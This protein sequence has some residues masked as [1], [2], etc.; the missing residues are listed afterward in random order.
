MSAAET[1]LLEPRPLFNP[2]HN[3]APFRL[4]PPA[5]PALSPPPAG[6]SCRAS[7]NRRLVYVSRNCVFNRRL[8][9]LPSAAKKVTTQLLLGHR[10]PPAR[11]GS[12]P[13]ADGCARRSPLFFLSKT[14]LSVRSPGC[15]V[16]SSDA[17]PA[18][19]SPNPVL[20]LKRP[21]LPLVD[22]PSAVPWGQYP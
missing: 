6:S 20:T 15:R 21:L 4:S 14:C 17:A 11:I 13:F 19:R 2:R 8:E 1:V 5:A 12:F 18:G 3:P 9:R 10:F 16:V 22:T 7:P